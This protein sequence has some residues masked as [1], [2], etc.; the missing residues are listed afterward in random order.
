MFGSLWD[1]RNYDLKYHQVSS[2]SYRLSASDRGRL[3]VHFVVINHVVSGS[4]LPE[5]R[6]VLALYEAVKLEV[7]DLQLRVA[8][9]CTL[10][11]NAVAAA[12]IDDNVGQI[13]AKRLGRKVVKLRGTL[14]IERAEM[15]A[16]QYR[17]I[18]YEENV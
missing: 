6:R 9:C 14:A 18:V 7:A 3:I 17:A 13:R 11:D 12:D 8:N 5:N 16:D 10:R 2:I 15:L 4:G 1:V